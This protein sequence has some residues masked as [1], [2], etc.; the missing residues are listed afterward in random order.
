M[1]L[2]IYFSL[3]SN[4]FSFTHSKSAA[5]LQHLQKWPSPHCD[6]PSPSA[7][8]SSHLAPSIFQTQFYLSGSTLLTAAPLPPSIHPNKPQPAPVTNGSPSERGRWFSGS[9]TS[10]PSTEV[11]FKFPPFLLVFLFSKFQYFLFGFCIL[12]AKFYT[13]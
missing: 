1:G 8:Q 4:L 11:R 5:P 13:L 9:G 2:N 3:L 6:S 12:F 10:A 7:S